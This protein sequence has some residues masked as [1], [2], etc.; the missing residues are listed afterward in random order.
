[1]TQPDFSVLSVMYVFHIVPTM[2]TAITKHK[3][4]ALAV[5]VQLR[6]TACDGRHG[7]TAETN[8][9]VYRYMNS[10]N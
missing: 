10:L 3:W 7:E 2:N 5:V 8:M 6:T 4:Y 9:T 1:M